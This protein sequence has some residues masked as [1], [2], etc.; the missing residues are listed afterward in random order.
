MTYKESL[1]LKSGLRLK[2]RLV[3]APMSLNMAGTNDFEEGDAAFLIKNSDDFGTIILGSHSV[4]HDV[5]CWSVDDSFYENK[6]IDT[7]IDD[8]HK[9]G[10]K[11]ILQLFEG[12]SFLSTTPLNTIS[13]DKIY[14]LLC[15]FMTATILA[16][17][18]GF[19]GVEIH[20]SNSFLLHQMLSSQ[21]N[22]R[23]D[24]YGGSVENRGRLLQEIVAAVRKTIERV[25]VKN[26]A[27]GVRIIP[28]DLGGGLTVHDFESVLNDTLLHQIDYIHLSLR[29]WRQVNSEN[30]LL[31]S[32]LKKQLLTD[33]KLITSGLIRDKV[34][35]SRALHYVDLVSIATPILN[36][37]GNDAYMLPYRNSDSNCLKLKN[38]FSV[39][40]N[41]SLNPIAVAP[42][43]ITTKNL[44]KGI[45]CEDI[46]FYSKLSKIAD[47]IFIGSVEVSERETAILDAVGLYNKSQMYAFRAL[48]KKI[49]QN[50]GLSIIQLYQ[51]HS[52]DCDVT[53]DLNYSI[54]SQKWGQLFY[55]LFK[56]IELAELSD[57][58]GIEFCFVSPSIWSILLKTS[59]GREL[60]E[61]I[62]KKIKQ[63]FPKLIIGIRFSPE[64]LISDHLLQENLRKSLNMIAS[65]YVSLNV[66]HINTLTSMLAVEIFKT[67]APNIPTFISG[68]IRSE[69]DIFDCYYKGMIPMK[70]RPFLDI[71]NK[72]Y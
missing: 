48:N 10:K 34:T 1:I 14:S 52:M 15:H 53:D 24:C 37:K 23:S 63:L 4:Y 71:K 66:T 50:K 5:N 69:W 35:A 67:L 32:E 6:A 56:S 46:E 11:V 29:N 47:I 22:Q 7:L 12:V 57:F 21:N 45:S 13:Q 59:D 58:D 9:K 62:C 65:D 54:T 26:F 68:N 18:K 61:V 60:M 39:S 2:N 36:N 8:C 25:E 27:I 64:Q 30:E 41:L 42:I 40:N 33:V 28:E 44:N 51:N 19:N 38:Q 55:D 70:G 16:Y 17:K 31:I 72:S 43:N 3:V 49:H 20:S